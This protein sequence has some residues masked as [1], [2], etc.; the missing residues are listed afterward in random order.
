M[1]DDDQ[2][3]QSIRDLIIDVCAVLYRQGY[4][5]VPIGAV[6]RLVGV[7][8]EKA[9]KH[10]NECFALDEEFSAILESK[11]HTLLKQAPDG[12]TLH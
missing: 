7:A 2:L 12:V 10:D 6:M 11:K 5:Q 1:Q 8:N 4:S 9:A 3:E